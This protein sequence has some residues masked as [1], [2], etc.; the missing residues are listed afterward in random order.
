MNTK[1]AVERKNNGYRYRPVLYFAMAYLFTWIFWVPAI[2]LKGNIAVIL[3]LLG[4]ISPAVVSTVFILASGSPALK[5]DLKE[6]LF[7]MPVLFW[8]QSLLFL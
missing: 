5:K 7:G 4:L 2:F 1:A 8:E 3:M 6:K